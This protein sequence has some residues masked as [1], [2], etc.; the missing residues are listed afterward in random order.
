MLLVGSAL[1]FA[2]V[3]ALAGIVK[4][5]I[6]GNSHFDIAYYTAILSFLWIHY[7]HDHFLFT[8]FEALDG[9]YR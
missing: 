1:I 8:D 6:D 3:Y 4:P 5:G 2:L 9:A 7:Y